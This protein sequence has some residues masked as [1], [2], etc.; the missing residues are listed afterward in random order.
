MFDLGW[1]SDA[2]ILAGGGD[3]CLGCAHLLRIA[4]MS[5]QCAW[6]GE[7]IVEEEQAETDGW[8]HFSDILGDLYPC[9]P[10]CLAARFGITSRV[11]L[12]RTL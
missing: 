5:E 6:C 7:P 1:V 11:G 12:R 10:G 9:C 4:R 3:Y 8:G 2:R